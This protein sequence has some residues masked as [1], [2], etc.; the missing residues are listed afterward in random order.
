M[1]FVARTETGEAIGVLGLIEMPFWYSRE[2]VLE[3]KWLYVKPKHRNGPALRALFKAAKDEAEARAKI[4][5]VVV[6]NPDRKRKRTK[7]GLVAELVGCVSAGY[8]LKLR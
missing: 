2:T 8:A 4:L 5:F 3:G 1:T 6:D 7:T